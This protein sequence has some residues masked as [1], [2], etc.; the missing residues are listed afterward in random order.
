ML[1]FLVGLSI[2]S[3]WI[4]FFGFVI[5]NPIYRLIVGLYLKKGRKQLLISV[6]VPLSIG[7]YA[8][9]NDKRWFHTLYY[10]IQILLFVFAL[11]GSFFLFY[12]RFA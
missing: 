3:L 4:S 5:I 10:G 7:Y 1:E 6:L 9:V 11:L 12:T 8:Q 2:V